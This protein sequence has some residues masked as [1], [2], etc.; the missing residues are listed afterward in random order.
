MWGT[1]TIENES[2]ESLQSKVDWYRDPVLGALTSF[3]CTGKETGKWHPA[4]SVTVH[5]VP[6]KC[7]VVYDGGKRT[8]DTEFALTLTPLYYVPSA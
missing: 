8:D 7:K 6:V 5:H 2:V 1:A 4:S 3:D